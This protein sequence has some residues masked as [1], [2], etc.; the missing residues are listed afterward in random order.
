MIIDYQLT[1]FNQFNN[2]FTGGKSLMVNHS[3]PTCGDT[4]Q[5]LVIDMINHS[6]SFLTYG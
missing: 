1:I 6:W 2:H 4:Y 5:W 3:Q